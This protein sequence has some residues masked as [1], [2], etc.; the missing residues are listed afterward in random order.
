[1]GEWILLVYPLA[2]LGYLMLAARWQPRYEPSRH[3][4]DDDR[5]A[6]RR[7]QGARRGNRR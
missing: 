3:D 4:A 2:L 1:M 5:E 7:A 6:P